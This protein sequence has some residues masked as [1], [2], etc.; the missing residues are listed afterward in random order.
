M[1]LRGGRPALTRRAYHR[2]NPWQRRDSP[3]SESRCVWGSVVFLMLLSLFGSGIAHVRAQ[4]VEAVG[5]G[6]VPEGVAPAVNGE[7]AIDT[8]QSLGVHTAAEPIAGPAT[9]TDLAPAGGRQRVSPVLASPSPSTARPSP[10]VFYPLSRYLTLPQASDACEI[11]INLPAFQLQVYRKGQPMRSYPIAVGKE[12]TPTAL[13]T[14]HIINKVADPTYYPPDWGKRGLKPIPP[15]PRNPVGTRWLGLAIKG[16]GIHGTNDPSSIGRAE[17]AGCIRMLN[18][19]VEELSDLVR[20][21]TP[22]TFVYEPLLLWLD[23]RSG[24]PMVQVHPD[25][26]GQRYPTV[27]RASEH[28]WQLGIQ[29]PVHEPGLSRIIAAASAKPEPIPLAAPVVV[30]ELGTVDGY[31]DLRG[32]HVSL[33]ELADL[34]GESAAVQVGVTV[35]VAGRGPGETWSS[36]YA[37]LPAA[38]AAFGLLTDA[39]GESLLPVGAPVNGRPASSTEE[40]EMLQ[41]CLPVDAVPP[42]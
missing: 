22:V 8:P 25:I 26:Y 10:L 29:S 9:S 16:Y 7:E 37:P 17:S 39:S 40:P 35:A 19:D 36:S 6:S 18:T 20:V 23:P 11:I 32:I 14:T 21:G 31:R 4:T 33:Q 34:L 2:A 13:G 12:V 42:S 1:A 30:G 5:T 15:G 24:W 38:A 27:E 3:G 28:L 41:P